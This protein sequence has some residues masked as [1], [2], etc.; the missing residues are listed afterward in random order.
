MADDSPPAEPPLTKPDYLDEYEVAGVVSLLIKSV[1]SDGRIAQ[2][3]TEI[4]TAN[5]EL[6]A[7]RLKRGKSVN[8]LGAFGFDPTQKNLW[9]AVHQVIGRDKYREAIAIGK[10]EAIP[11]S[12]Q[13]VDERGG[14]NATE[15]TEAESVIDKDNATSSPPRVG[16]A[17][18]SI[19][20]DRVPLGL[21]V[22][23]IKQSLSKSYGIEGH[24]KTPGMTLY[25]LLKEGKVARAGRYWFYVDP[26]DA[27][28]TENPGGETPGNNNPEKEEEEAAEC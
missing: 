27:G 18:M 19:L 1:K 26:S 28:K 5:A 4:A 24:E 11:E 2:L 13:S 23:D 12:S 15:S 14:T 25:R 6:S 8:A 7:E 21:R 22:A 20:K 10:G 16:E 17:I 9:T 3:T